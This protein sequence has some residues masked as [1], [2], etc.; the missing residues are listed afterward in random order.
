MASFRLHH[1]D[2]P[3][4]ESAKLPIVE[5]II[6]YWLIDPVP[7]LGR[8]LAR[9]QLEIRPRANDCSGETNGPPIEMVNK[10]ANE[11]EFANALRAVDALMKLENEEW[12]VSLNQRRV[13][14]PA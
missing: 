2:H 14:L 4:E 8:R 5:R 10:A 7:R 9:H 13:E 1:H 6:V 12:W 3:P 11:R